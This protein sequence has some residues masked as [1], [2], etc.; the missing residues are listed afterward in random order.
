MNIEERNGTEVVNRVEFTRDLLEGVKQGLSELFTLPLIVDSVSNNKVTFKTRVEGEEGFVE[1]VVNI[2]D[3]DDLEL[4]F[5]TYIV[6]GASTLAMPK[7]IVHFSEKDYEETQEFIVDGLELHDF[8]GQVISSGDTQ[9]TLKVELGGNYLRNLLKMRGIVSTSNVDSNPKELPVIKSESEL[10]DEL[11]K[12][13]FEAEAYSLAK[14][15]LR[16]RT[17]KLRIR[18]LKMAQ[19]AD[20]AGHR[21][22]SMAAKLRW[23]TSR[24][25][26]L[27]GMKKFHRSAD[28]K[29]LHQMV[30]KLNQES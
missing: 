23:R 22:R 16:S 5:V 18:K 14:L 17:K 28:G 12:E 6:L 26:I 3:E 20:P 11:F 7:I 2:S 19:R 30:G 13:T 29:R 4:L 27:R 9:G 25:K 8:S 21:K 24:S 10:V 15:K 1:E